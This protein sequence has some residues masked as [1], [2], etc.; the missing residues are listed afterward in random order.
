MK[1]YW[2]LCGYD[3][4]RPIF[5][6]KLSVG[7]FTTEQMND[8]LRALTAK[9]SLTFGEIVGAYA[10]RKTKGANDLLAVR[11]DS[12]Y[13]TYE[14]GS[15]PYFAASIVDENGKIPRLRNR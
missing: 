2:R 15:N 11:R 13:P 4:N 1:Q 14:C 12:V 9:A 8:L 10:K 3:G 6:S 7:Q 5:E